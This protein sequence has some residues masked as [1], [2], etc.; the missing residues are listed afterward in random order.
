MR[1]GCAIRLCCNLRKREHTMTGSI[2]SA[3]SIPGVITPSETVTY[4]NNMSCI[5]LLRW[6]DYTGPLMSRSDGFLAGIS[7]AI[8]KALH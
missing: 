4:C 2:L 8:T 3:Q 1:I 7:G 6:A 5:P